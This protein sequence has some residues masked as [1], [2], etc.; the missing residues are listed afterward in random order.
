MVPSKEPA[1]VNRPM[2]PVGMHVKQGPQCSAGCVGLWKSSDQ[3]STTDRAGLGSFLAACRLG[4]PALK[5][6]PFCCCDG[7]ALSGAASIC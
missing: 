4:L 2:L 7:G 3:P 5:V 6:T 1:L